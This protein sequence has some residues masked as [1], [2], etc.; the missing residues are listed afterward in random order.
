MKL[1][2]PSS[3]TD[4]PFS[5]RRSV[6]KNHLQILMKNGGGFELTTL[7]TIE[8][9]RSEI[10]EARSAERFAIL[11]TI[12]QHGMASADLAP[13][14]IAAVVLASTGQTVTVTPAGQVQ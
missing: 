1:E 12:T 3:T 14:Q 11:Q 5:A 13:D 8:E 10:A 4:T 7:M 6:S 9:I 2:G